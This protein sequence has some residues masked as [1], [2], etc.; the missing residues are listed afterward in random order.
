MRGVRRF[1]SSLTSIGG[2]EDQEVGRWGGPELQIRVQ[3][4]QTWKTDPRRGGENHHLLQGVFSPAG[5]WVF[6]AGNL[7]NSQEIL[8]KTLIIEQI[9]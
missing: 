3:Q 6:P 2:G 9:L 4:V 1:T 8:T 5:V 7:Q